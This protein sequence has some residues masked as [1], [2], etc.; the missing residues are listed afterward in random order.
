VRIVIHTRDG[1]DHCTT[2]ITVR[3]AE[4]KE[5]FRMVRVAHASLGAE[6]DEAKK[7]PLHDVD[8]GMSG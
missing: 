1:G 7:C 6:L 3:G 5:A 4:P 2:K 8:V